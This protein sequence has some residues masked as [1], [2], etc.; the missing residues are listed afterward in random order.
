M[1]SIPADITGWTAISNAFT[2]TGTTR[3]VMLDG[4]LPA[5]FYLLWITRLTGT[6]G[7]W[8]AEVSDVKL[9]ED[10]PAGG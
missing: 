9:F 4:T 7:A 2:M 5:R 10:S 3:T 1:A 8:S 6:P